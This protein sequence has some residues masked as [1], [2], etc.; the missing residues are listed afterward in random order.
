[1]SAVALSIPVI[2]TERL[3]LRGPNMADFEAFAAAC[4]SERARFVG[5]PQSR[6]QGW[7]AFL[8]MFGH[9]ALRGFGMW[10]AEHRASGVPAGR[11]GMIFNDGWQEPELGWHVFDGFEGQG[12]A[13]EA[14]RAA[15]VHAARHQDL[16]RVI[17]YIA[18]DNSRSQALAKRL[19]ARVERDGL[20]ND[21]PVQIWRHPSVLEDAA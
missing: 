12:L 9:W 7:S 16:D 19:G 14:A 21:W 10:M 11:I 18:P 13:Q 6:K 5:G 15:R 20:L 1:M 3:I 8:A 4:A 17:S 2:E